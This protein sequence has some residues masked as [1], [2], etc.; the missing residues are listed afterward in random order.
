MSEPA[1]PQ[2]SDVVERFLRYVQVD[3]Q[4]DPRNI[5]VVPSTACQ[6]DLVNL[7]ADELR[8]MGAQDVITTEHAYVTAGLEG[9]PTLAL[10]AHVDA[11]SSVPGNGVKPQVVDYQGG[12]L[13]MGVVDGVEVYTDPSINPELNDMV[14]RQIICTD[15][16]TLLAADDKAG[17]AEIMALAKRLL[18]DPSIPHPRLAISFVPDEEL[19][20]GAALLD[21]DEH[22]ATWGYTLDGGPIGVMNYECFNA[23]EAKVRFAGFSVHPGT[24][25]DRMV[26]AVEIACQYENLMPPQ[27]KPQYTEGYD[28]FIHLHDLRGGVESAEAWYIIRDHDSGRL[29]AKKEVMRQA[30]AFLNERYGREIVSIEINDQ[31]RNMAEVVTQ[32]PHLIE[33]ARK[34]YAANGYTMWTEPMRGGT[35]GAQLCYRGLPCANISAG[36]HN[37]HGVKEFVGVYELED[38]VDVLQTLVGLYA[39]PQAE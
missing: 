12:K 3:T 26:N 39:E 21:L 22:G 30:A 1:E 13:V 7:L 24:S 35:D 27:A 25:K 31:Y 11:E 16:R 10:N 17:V 9:L 33:N 29:E 5:D 6:Q 37:A 4:G 18:D 20:H 19:G 14:G 36:Y 2:Y 28:G 15:G 34:A 32:H 23:A 8:A 38:M